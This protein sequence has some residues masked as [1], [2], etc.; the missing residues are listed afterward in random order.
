MY[1]VKQHIKELYKLQGSPEQIAQWVS[2]LLERDHFVC[3]EDKYE[4]RLINLL[5]F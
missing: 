5:S 4:V 1:D 2:Y 3:A